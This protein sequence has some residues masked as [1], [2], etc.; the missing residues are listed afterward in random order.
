MYSKEECLLW[1]RQYF[2]KIKKVSAKVDYRGWLAEIIVEHF[3]KAMDGNEFSQWVVWHA[4]MD[5]RQMFE[6]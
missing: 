1:A 3:Q 4:V 2:D 5:L 6:R